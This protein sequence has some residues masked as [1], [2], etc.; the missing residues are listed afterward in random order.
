MQAIIYILDVPPMEIQN[1]SVK[2]NFVT[3]E[4][5]MCVKT[6]SEE[7]SYAIRLK[8]RVNFGE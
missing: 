4:T 1:M 5:H 6:G 8:L 2:S 7:L 3:E